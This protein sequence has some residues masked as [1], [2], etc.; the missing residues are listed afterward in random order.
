MNHSRYIHIWE[1]LFW[2]PAKSSWW[3]MGCKHHTYPAR[4]VLSS[5]SSSFSRS[6][7]PFPFSSSPSFPSAPFSFVIVVFVVVIVVFVA[8]VMVHLFPFVRPISTAL[9]G[10]NTRWGNCWFRESLMNA[11]DLSLTV[12]KQAYLGNK[13]Y[14]LKSP[15]NSEINTHSKKM[16]ASFI[17]IVILVLL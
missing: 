12:T 3:K 9:R 13:T 16:W 15:N 14:D 17:F 7:V 6:F 11:W 10:C 5:S 2:T 1:S 8:V 4:S